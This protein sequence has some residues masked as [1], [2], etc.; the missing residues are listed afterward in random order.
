MP[1]LT[2]LYLM[3]FRFRVSLCVCLGFVL[4]SFGEQVQELDEKHDVSGKFA[5]VAMS[6]H[7]KAVEVDTK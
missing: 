3:G 7:A 4:V 5:A 1:K 2:A 6:A